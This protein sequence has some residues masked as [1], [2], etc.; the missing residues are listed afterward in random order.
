MDQSKWPGHN[1]VSA[2][3]YIYGID[4]VC[5]SRDVDMPVLAAVCDVIGPRYLIIF[6]PFWEVGTFHASLASVALSLLH[7]LPL[8]N[9]LYTF[10]LLPSC[11]GGD[12]RV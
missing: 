5:L 6:H 11:L 3:L 12:V 9:A 1:N 10:S 2:C 7:L 4:R 8:P